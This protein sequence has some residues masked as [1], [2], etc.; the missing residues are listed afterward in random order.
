MDR[1]NRH[2]KQGNRGNSKRCRGVSQVRDDRQ[3]LG[4]GDMVVS[5]GEP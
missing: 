4:Y 2:L 1:A 5:P 3:T